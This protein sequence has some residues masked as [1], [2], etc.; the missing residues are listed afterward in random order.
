M[1]EAACDHPRRGRCRDWLGSADGGRGWERMRDR[2]DGAGGSGPD[3]SRLAVRGHGPGPD[4]A[5]LD[6]AVG[7]A[8]GRGEGWSRVIRGLR[9]V[10]RPARLRVD[11]GSPRTIWDSEAFISFAFGSTPV[12]SSRAPQRDR[13][14]DH[15]G[16]HPR[17]R[18]SPV[19]SPR[20]STGREKV[21]ASACSLGSRDA[22]HC[23]RGRGR[24]RPSCSPNPAGPR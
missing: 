4:A 18:P 19:R 21:N 7:P 11:R 5:G 20:I 22:P 15:L 9:D 6:R 10:D 16:S 13:P 12:V 1:R 17:P 24:V 8:P 2:A 23:G 3:E 14:E